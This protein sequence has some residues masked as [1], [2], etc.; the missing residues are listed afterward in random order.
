MKGIKRV[1][2][3]YDVIVVGAGNGGLAAAATTAKSGLR[4]LLL[5][6]HN[7]PGGA[8]TSFRRGR[9]EFEPALH[10][11]ASVGPKELPGAIRLMFDS[12]GAQVDWHIERSTFHLV[13]PSEGIDAA[14]PC[15]VKEFTDEM[16]RQVPGCRESVETMFTLAKKGVEATEYLR[17]GKPNPILM[18][19]KY[20]DFMRM[21]SHTLEEG[22]N[23]IGMPKK[24]QDILAA[25]WCYLGSPSDELDFF[26]YVIMLYSYVALGAGMAHMRSHELSLALEKVVRDHGGEVWYNSEVTKLLTKDGRACGVAVGDRELY[27]DH[28]IVNCYPHAAFSTMMDER[29]IPEKALKLANTREL[30]LS[31]FTVYLGMNKTAQELGIK[32][33]SNFIAP[34]ADTREQYNRCC[35]L[36]NSGYVIMNCL[37][38]AIPDSSPEGTCTLFFTGMYFGDV[39]KDVKPEDYKKLKTRIAGEYIE[40]CEK[41]LGICIK[42]YIEEIVTAA[43]PTFTRYMGTPRGTPYGYTFKLWD[44][45]VQRMMALEEDQPMPGLRFCGAHSEWGDGFSSAYNSGSTAGRLTAEDVKE[46]K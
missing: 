35:S 23:A 39:W 37:N 20:A 31:F 8:A 36:E 10:E 40:T 33:Y 7:L 19:T 11:L 29:A 27:A 43:P 13:V 44:S 34:C 9:F 41:A 21:A 45:I 14:M 25:Y 46:D 2:D 1:R 6:R 26:Y 28:V 32:E 5:E 24:A 12:L 3:S 17:R 18:A 16:E 30:G 15:G 38:C 4:T 42:P 22:L